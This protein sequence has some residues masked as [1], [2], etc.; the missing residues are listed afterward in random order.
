MLTG[1][2]DKI[3]A[4]IGNI[5]D[6]I[7]LPRLHGMLADY[8]F[9]CIDLKRAHLKRILS[10]R[11]Y[12]GYFLTSPLKGAAMQYMDEVSETARKVGCVNTKNRSSPCCRCVK[13]E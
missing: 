8:T 12:S 7:V 2:K 10:D 6:K 11:S 4:F 1:F 5:K 3:I 13:C 9:E